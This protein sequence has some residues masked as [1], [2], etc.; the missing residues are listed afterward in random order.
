[1]DDQSKLSDDG[2]VM[3]CDTLVLPSRHAVIKRYALLNIGHLVS[4]AGLLVTTVYLGRTLGVQSF[5]IVIYFQ[6]ATIL[7]AM[8]TD[9]GLAWQASHE[10]ARIYG[11]WGF[12]HE[13]LRGFNEIASLRLSLAS[14]LCAGWWAATYSSEFLAA[15]RPLV[16]AFGISFF[17]S[18]I[19]P[20][21]VLIAVGHT[22]TLVVGRVIRSLAFLGLVLVLV[23]PSLEETWVGVAYTLAFGISAGY[24]L[25]HLRRC[26]GWTPRLSL[27]KKPL[28]KLLSATPFF[29]FTVLSQLLFLIGLLA[30]RWFVGPED[31]GLCAAAFRL[32]V[33][34]VPLCFFVVTALMPEIGASRIA[35]LP[36]TVGFFMLCSAAFGLPLVAIGALESETFVQAVLGP[37]YAPAGPLFGILLYSLP[38]LSVALLAGAALN[39]MGR[40]R[41]VMAVITISALLQIPMAAVATKMFGPLGVAVATDVAMLI[42]ATALGAMLRGLLTDSGPALI[43]LLLG[44]AAM[45]IC[46]YA[47]VTRIPWF[48]TLAARCALEGCVAIGYFLLL[49]RFRIDPIALLQSHFNKSRSAPLTGY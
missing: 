32:L 9:C 27:D 37:A 30:S 16:V 23:G 46:L 22:R 29:A 28:Q 44:A 8:G 36:A 19:A 49:R 17:I 42:C 34:L 13:L 24:L 12:K 45:H 41:R 47:T 7:L 43:G 39:Q 18:A 25:V 14:L 1:V 40:A 2:E 35:A 10:L 5:G 38:L 6:S 20:E 11:K 4:K 21:W 26:W 15:H 48:R 33:A 31:A 3:A